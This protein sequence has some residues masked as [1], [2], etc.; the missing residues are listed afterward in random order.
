[1]QALSSDIACSRQIITKALSYASPRA[2]VGTTGA[3]AARGDPRAGPARRT[4]GS[5]SGRACA[6]SAA[7]TTKQVF[8]NGSMDNP[9]TSLISFP[10]VLGHEVVGTVASVGPAV[11]SAGSASASS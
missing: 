6:E 11:T 8:L 3:D 5:S 7:A 9:M 1:M 4:T 10:Q 2:V